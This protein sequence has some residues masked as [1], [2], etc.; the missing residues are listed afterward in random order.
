MFS[1]YVPISDNYGVRGVGNTVTKVAGRGTIKLTFDI[2]HEKTLT[3]V[4]KN[5]L[6]LPNATNCLLSI[7][8]FAQTN[9]TANFSKEQVQLL[10]KEGNLIGT[11]KMEGGLYF[12]KA[13]A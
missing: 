8:K 5:V 1:D 12:L 11:G 6:H 13:R 3:H 7:S 9:G 2:G 10:D 4:L